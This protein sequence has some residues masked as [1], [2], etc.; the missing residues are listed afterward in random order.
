MAATR[1][2]VHAARRL[3]PVGA[4]VAVCLVGLA[5]FPA[6]AQ[7]VGRVSSFVMD[8]NTGRVLQQYNPDLKRY[9]ASLTKLMTLYLAFKALRANSIALDQA[10]PVSSHAASMEPSKLGLVPGSYLTVEQAILAL[11]TKSANDAACALGELI[12]GGSEQQFARLMTQQA[13]MLGM[14]DS[15]FRNASGLPD[16]QQVTTARDLA[17]LAMRLMRD[18]PGDYHYFSV[19]AFMFHGRYISNHDSMLRTYPG[20]DGLKTGYTAEAGHN[21]VSSSVH[22]N[23]RLIGI[24]L[25]ARTNPQRSAM[26]SNLF[27]DGFHME[28][29][30][31]EPRPS[32]R[33]WQAPM[34]M[35]SDNPFARR[36]ARGPV[37]H[38]HHR[39]HHATRLR[40][41]KWHLT[42]Y[43]VGSVR[44][45]SGRSGSGRHSAHLLGAQ[46]RRVLAHGPRLRRHH[47]S[48][49]G[50]RTLQRG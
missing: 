18:F 44:S 7:Y 38:G 31:V 37:W 1:I 49:S 17:T 28:G 39:F 29:V 10:V 36:E 2:F 5:A 34:L 19:P 32:P 48:M 25:G 46:M 13:R 8:A 41:V 12:G 23:V 24:V 43:H 11:V 14:T 3:N 16:P 9:P 40:Y 33:A 50:G 20:V 26:M 21:L 15:T 30:P 35:V 22:G 42:A 6:R 45:G 47:Q 27:D 4:L